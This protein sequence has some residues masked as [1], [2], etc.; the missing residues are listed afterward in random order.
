MDYNPESSFDAVK[1][2]SPFRAFYEE[3]GRKFIPWM[4]ETVERSWKELCNEHEDVRAFVGEVL[5]FSQNVKVGVTA[6]LTSRFLLANVVAAKTVDP[7][8]RSVREGMYL[9]WT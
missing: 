3:M 2:I 9:T 6:H 8:R 1:F 5:A 7:F 4:D